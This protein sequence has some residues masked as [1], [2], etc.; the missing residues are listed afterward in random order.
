MK[1]TIS[2]KLKLFLGLMAVG[3]LASGQCEMP[4]DSL[5]NFSNGLVASGACNIS[6]NYTP[7]EEYLDNYSTIHIR[8]DFHVFQKDDSSDNF[9]NTTNDKNH[10]IAILDD[11]NRRYSNLVTPFP[12]GNLITDS[13][14]K[15]VLGGIYFYQN[16]SIAVDMNRSKANQALTIIHN[17]SS[18]SNDQKF[19]TLHIIHGIGIYGGL[20]SWF[21]DKDWIYVKNYYGDYLADSYDGTFNYSIEKN[22]GHLSHEIGHSLGLW[23][24]FQGGNNCSDIG[25]NVQGGT[26]NMMDYVA[27][28]YEYESLSE[29]QLGIIQKN[30]KGLSGGNI[31]DCVIPTFCSVNPLENIEIKNGEND[32]WNNPRFLNGDLL[33]KNGGVLT[34]KCYTSV[35][36]DGKIIIEKGGSLIID[37]GIISNECN[38]QW[39]G[40]YVEGD[41]NKSQVP[42]SNQGYV[43]II[44]GG[45]IEHARTGITLCGLN[46]SG[47]IDLSKSGGLVIAKDAIFQNNWRDI[48]FTGYHNLPYTVA[49]ATPNLSSFNNCSFITTN[50][51]RSD[52]VNDIWPNVT[53]WGVVQVKFTGC[54]WHDQRDGSIDPRLDDYLQ[55]R[56][57]LFA[58]D[59]SYR[60]TD[61]FAMRPLEIPS[62]SIATSYF[63]NMRYGIQSLDNPLAGNNFTNGRPSTVQDAQFENCLGGIYLSGVEGALLTRNNFQIEPYDVPNF[64]EIEAYGIYLDNSNGYQTEGNTFSSNWAIDPVAN[65]SVGIITNANENRTNRI[66]RNYFNDNLL[67]AEAIG[68]NRHQNVGSY[69]EIGLKYRC[70][71]FGS[72]SDN[73]LDIWATHHQ[74]IP[75]STAQTGL[76]Q[77][78]NLFDPMGNLFGVYG[79]SGH[80]HFNYLQ[81]PSSFVQYFHHDLTVEPRVEP[82]IQWGVNNFSVGSSWTTFNAECP[83]NTSSGYLVTQSHIDK[84]DFDLVEMKIKR[85]QLKQFVD[86]GN[87]IDVVQRIQTVNANTIGTLISDLTSYSPYLSDEVLLT[88]STSNTPITH[89]QIRDILMLNPHS[90]GNPNVIAS[91]QN[92]SDNY[93]ASYIADILSL[94]NTLTARDSLVAEVYHHSNEYDNGVNSI[95][96]RALNDSVDRFEELVEPILL[97]SNRPQHRYRLAAL[98][99]S[100]GDSTEAQQILSAIPT[101]ESF[102][103]SQLDYHNDLMALRSLLKTWRE[104]IIDLSNLDSSRI[105]A[106]KVYENKTNGIQYKVYPILALNKSSTYIAPIYMPSVP[107]SSAMS[108]NNAQNNEGVDDEIDSSIPVESRLYIDRSMNSNYLN[109]YPNPTQKSLNVAYILEDD[110]AGAEIIIYGLDGKV[111]NRIVISDSHGRETIDVSTMRNGQYI[112]AVVAQGIKLKQLRFAIT[113]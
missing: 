25:S 15:F 78:G 98:Y 104:Q 101:M 53:M 3:V 99:D 95:L 58:M 41:P 96:I 32:V 93:P 76:P 54:T 89:L 9:Q 77:Q 82:N 42:F 28:P 4:H 2:T 34:I 69:P 16:S 22:S 1:K 81:S 68:W 43:R 71:D 83:D 102:E 97:A 65:L 91:L 46:S 33:V 79:T 70:N 26:N 56:D 113:R 13:R 66:Y 14:I 108:T 109:V 50:E 106:L 72:S 6:S 38:Q 112:C 85:T 48:S 10:L 111:L 74:T 20:A 8:V 87:T 12:S 36:S 107:P 80:R 18:L 67:G 75:Y 19:N 44:N 30:L 90:S 103:A 49:F 110:I 92:R 105:A 57:G 100:R 39:Q 23:H 27:S 59:A 64:R 11:V 51:Y 24:T 35:P 88:L 52:H 94:N 21:N 40:I 7:N 17:N 84:V 55:R 73:N 62:P 37:G 60:I 63:K 29:C 47:N 5:P 61:L 45:T 86:N 31:S